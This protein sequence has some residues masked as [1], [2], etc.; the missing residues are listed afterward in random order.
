MS[1]YFDVLNIDKAVIPAC[2]MVGS[3]GI[4][5]IVPFA[6]NPCFADFYDF[7]G[8]PFTVRFIIRVLLLHLLDLLDLLFL[9][10][11]GEALGLYVI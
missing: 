4:I 2:G 8:Y 5:F 11:L 3:G 6:A 7:H 9:S 10:L 1:G